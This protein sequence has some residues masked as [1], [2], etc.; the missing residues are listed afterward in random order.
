MIAMVGI[1]DTEST[2]MMANILIKSQKKLV[3][4]QNF[5]YRRKVLKM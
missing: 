5:Q 2:A 1:T 4:L 3:A